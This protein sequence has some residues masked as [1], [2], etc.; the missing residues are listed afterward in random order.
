MNP[1]NSGHHRNPPMKAYKSKI[2][3]GNLQNR[4]FVVTRAATESGKMFLDVNV[5]TA[6]T[7]ADNEIVINAICDT[8]SAYEYIIL[9]SSTYTLYLNLAI[10]YNRV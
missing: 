10:I 1:Q 2:A 7:H 5:A 9:Y 6:E 3:A 8:G 4:V